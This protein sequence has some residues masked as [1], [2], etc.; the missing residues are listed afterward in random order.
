MAIM[1]NLTPGGLARLAA[2]YTARAQPAVEYSTEPGEIEVDVRITTELHDALK[3]VV[4]HNGQALTDVAR[5]VL[6]TTASKVTASE[7][8]KYR[9][10]RAA[11]ASDAVE[12]AVKRA[13]SRGLTEEEV[14]A[15]AAKARSRVMRQRLPLR[16]YGVQ[17]YRLRFTLPADQYEGARDAIQ[18]SGKSV[19]VA[20]EEGLYAYARNQSIN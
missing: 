9:E 3:V 6:F 10:A 11:R 17:R 19:A 4:A 20:V 8:R 7:V 1:T 12:R 2:T 14:L 5:A 15:A 16:R 13:T 18:A